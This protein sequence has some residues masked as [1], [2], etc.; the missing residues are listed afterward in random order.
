MTALTVAIDGT[1][2]L[3]NGAPP[4]A[5]RTYAGTPLDGLL[6]N[7]RMIQAVADDENPDTCRLWAYPDTGRWDPERNTDEFCAMLPVYAEHGLR[8]VTIGLQGGGS[9]YR[10]EIM[11]ACEITGFTP[12][13]ELKEA[14]QQRLA[15]VL[16]ATAENGIV[17]IVSLFY[18][19]QVRRLADEKSRWRAVENAVRW[20]LSTGHRHILLEIANEIRPDWPT[21]FTPTRI[22]EVIRFAQGLTDEGRRLLVG[23]SCFPTDPIPTESW[24]QAED[25]TLPH[26]NDQTPPALSARLRAIKATAAFQER[27]RPILIN[28]DSIFLD[29][30]DAAL[31]EGVSWGFYHQGFGSDFADRRISWRGKGREHHYDDLSGF[32]T[33][34]VN[35]SLNDPAKHAF[36]SKTRELTKEREA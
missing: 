30:F 17:V 10:P 26:G 20:L 5:G 23:C 2:F 1:R 25:F 4:L 13:G 12:D 24:L 11:K 19:A 29:N 9:N 36:F 34:P 16:E 6:L 22:H 18:W 21:P 15:R 35:W 3:L 33:L 31:R 28:E 14:W 32:Q 8:A 7:S 27:P